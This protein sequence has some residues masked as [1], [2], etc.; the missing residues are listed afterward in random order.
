MIINDE[1]DF[2]LCV[3]YT[4]RLQKGSS[5]VSAVHGKQTCHAIQSTPYEQLVKTHHYADSTGT[6]K[7]VE[8]IFAEPQFKVETNL[9]SVNKCKALPF[10]SLSLTR[11]KLLL[12]IR[13]KVYFISLY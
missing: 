6:F 4:I 12:P 2:I 3:L 13:H 5:I 11:L 10:Q 8:I 9:T 7:S 1:E